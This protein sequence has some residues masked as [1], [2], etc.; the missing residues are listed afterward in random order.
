[1]WTCP[2]ILYLSIIIFCLAC[3]KHCD[4]NPI[5]DVL[6]NKH[7]PPTSYLP[8]MLQQKIDN[9]LFLFMYRPT[10]HPHIATPQPVDPRLDSSSVATIAVI[11]VTSSVPPTPRIS[12]PWTKTLVSIPTGSLRGHAISAGPRTDVG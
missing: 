7:N 9:L 2:F 5:D 8:L 3:V 1:M 6:P 11:A 12:C 4:S 10:Q